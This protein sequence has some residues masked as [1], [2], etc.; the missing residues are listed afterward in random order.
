[1]NDRPQLF[2][3]LIALGCVAAMGQR[4]GWA[5]ILALLPLLV[6]ALGMIWYSGSVSRALGRGRGLRRARHPT[7]PAAIRALGW[8]LLLMPLLA[9]AL[10]RLRAD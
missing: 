9:L 2:S 5:G 7:P 8:V 4:E 3:A 10:Q 1:M 6:P